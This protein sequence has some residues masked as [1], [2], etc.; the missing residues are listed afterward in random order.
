MSAVDSF[1]YAENG[2]ALARVDRI[3]PGLNGR[4]K[5]F[6]PYLALPGKGFEKTAGLNGMKLPLY[7]VD[8]VRAA[9]GAGEI[10]YFVEGEGKCDRLREAL[11]KAGS[12]EAVTTLFGGASAPMR[13]EHLRSLGGARQ[14]IVLGDSDNAG[15]RARRSR[16]QRIADAYPTCD[17]RAIDFYADRTDGSDVADWLAEGH[18]CHELV[19][20]AGATPRVEWQPVSGPRTSDDGTSGLVTICASD[21]RSKRSEWFALDRIPFA[22]VTLFDGPGGV[23]K[24]TAFTGIIAA[25]SV[26]RS[27]F[28][29]DSIEPVI[30]LIVVEEDSLGILKMRL[31]VAGA[32]LSRVHFITGVRYGDITDPFT[33]P[34]HIAELER[35][36][37]ETGARLVY[38]DALFSHLE[39]DGDGR[40]PQQVRRALRP[41]VEMV[42]R[43]G[44]AFTAT[45]H[46]TKATGPASVRALGSAELGNVARSI[47]SFGPH[48]D[49]ESRGIIAVTKH[50]LAPIVPTLAYRI[51]VV[52]ASD[53]DGQFCEAIKVVLDGEAHD[54]TADDLTMQ[55][56]GDPDERNAAGDWLGDHL[57]DGEWHNATDI[58]K[59][60]RKDGAGSP[61]TVRRAARR[62]GVEK[63]RSGFP[64]R[65]KWRL[66]AERS[67]IAH[68]QS[69]SELEQ[70]GEQ[71]ETMAAQRALREGRFLL[72]R[73]PCSYHNGSAQEC[74][75][76]CGATFA[77]HHAS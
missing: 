44:V 76:S 58:Y 1:V 26:G 70:T 56:P 50:N 23:G 42:A 67:Q 66:R 46:W 47:L 3:E 57:G 12:A 68:S 54:V 38:V 69:V 31:Q 45:R 6:L 28:D 71:T 20:L 11:L 49:D 37:G 27:F 5:D 7:R 51:E 48:P 13:P 29:D 59:A 65:S 43:T 19:A 17:V 72:K 52:T 53:D 34:K 22:A 61:A 10:I 74:C 24:T 21:V 41:I 9:I 4:D 33:L 32:D 30:T 36:L 55:L 77:E 25:A 64:S 2:V 35:K 73:A 62:L 60:A 40:M 14:V 75:L 63:D 15:R 39:L 18:A 8:E 16:A